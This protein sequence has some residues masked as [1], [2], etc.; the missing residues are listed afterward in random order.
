[1]TEAPRHLMTERPLMVY[2]SLAAALDVEAAILLQQVFFYQTSDRGGELRDGRNWIYNTGT[3]WLDKHFPFVSASTFER[4]VKRLKDHGLLLVRT[5]I[6]KQLRRGNENNMR[7]Y[8][9]DCDAVDAAMKLWQDK[10][11]PRGGLYSLI[12]QER[13][14]ATNAGQQSPSQNDNDLSSHAGRSQNDNHIGKSP[15][16]NDNDFKGGLG[17]SISVVTPALSSKS[18]NDQDTYIAQPAVAVSA[19]HS[20]IATLKTYAKKHLPEPT[21]GQALARLAL[22]ESKQPD[23][24]RW[25]ADFD[26][27]WLFYPVKR[28]RLA[29]E[30]LFTELHRA[31]RSTRIAEMLRAVCKQVDAWQH[32]VEANLRVPDF[33]YPD[34]WLEK[35]CWLDEVDS[36]P[37]LAPAAPPEEVEHWRREGFRS[38]ADYEQCTF[39]ETKAKFKAGQRFDAREFRRQWKL[40]HGYAVNPIPSKECAT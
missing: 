15:S 12:Q 40:N 23:P 13:E 24:D 30:K 22:H 32:K 3:N 37:T 7:W 11:R 2:P 14:R 5:D 9:V 17:G 10:G 21:Q 27:F 35:G 8:S 16:Q 6:S 29:A 31:G 33:K 18:S 34:T 25:P 19:A 26:L 4:L 36:G 39:D 28:N 20:L 1:M 38:E